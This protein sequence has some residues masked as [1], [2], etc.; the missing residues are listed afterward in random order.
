[1]LDISF[2]IIMRDISNIKHLLD[3]SNIARMG[4]ISCIEGVR[5][6]VGFKKTTLEQGIGENDMRLC[7]IHTGHFGEKTP[8]AWR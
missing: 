7:F 4:Y 1:V 5:R 3:I 6:K 2:I 8:C